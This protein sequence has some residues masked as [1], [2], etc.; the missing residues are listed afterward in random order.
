MHKYGGE[1]VHASFPEQKILK[2]DDANSGPWPEQ[3]HNFM[4]VCIVIWSII[5]ESLHLFYFIFL[6]LGPILW[7]HWSGYSSSEIHGRVWHWICQPLDSFKQMLM[8]R[9]RLLCAFIIKYSYCWLINISGDLLC[10]V[11]VHHR[12]YSSKSSTYKANGTKFEIKYG[13]GSLSGF[14]STDTLSVCWEIFH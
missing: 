9:Y 3:L 1:Q 14:L 2:L 4:D 5:F 12:Y 10:N 8:D 6:I 13:S 7:R 11:G